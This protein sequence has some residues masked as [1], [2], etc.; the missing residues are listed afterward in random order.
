MNTGEQGCFGCAVGALIH[1]VQ[2][3]DDVKVRE[4]IERLEELF[5]KIAKERNLACMA[6]M[7][8]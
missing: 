5:A 4:A 7:N 2:R 3:G 6:T 1:A 8:D